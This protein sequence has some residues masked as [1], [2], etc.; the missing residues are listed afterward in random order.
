[1]RSWFYFPPSAR[2]PTTLNCIYCTQV[3]YVLSACTHHSSVSCG[4]TI[5]RS[6]GQLLRDY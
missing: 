5:P 3:V 2:L 4:V 6:Y 1:M